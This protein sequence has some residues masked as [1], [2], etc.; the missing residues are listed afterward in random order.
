[1]RQRQLR[2]GRGGRAGRVA[3]GDA[4]GAGIVDV[5][6]VDAH[7]AADDQAEL[8]ALRLVDVVFA[9]F[10]LGAD[11][12]RVEI[13]QRRAQLLRLIKLLYYLMAHV[14]QLRHGGLIHSVGHQNTHGQSPFLLFIQLLS[15]PSSG[16][17][18]E[19][20]CFASK[21]R[22]NATSASTPSLGMAL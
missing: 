17:G 14:A 6:V 13:A 3:H 4:A 2:H 12:D 16:E 15:I 19:A 8:A 11:D 18:A 5:D 1:M 10:R 9:N 22:R 7:A 20:Q 21:S